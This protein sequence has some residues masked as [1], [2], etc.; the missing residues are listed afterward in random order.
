MNIRQILHILKKSSAG[1][2][3]GMFL[4]SLFSL[5]QASD[6]P[7]MPFVPTQIF[8]NNIPGAIQIIRGNQQVTVPIFIVGGPLAYND[9]KLELYMWVD[10]NGSILCIENPTGTSAWQFKR[11]DS[12]LDCEGL[13]PPLIRL[14]K[15]FHFEFPVQ[16]GALPLSSSELTVHMCID[17][18]YN[19]QL[20]DPTLSS[21]VYCVG[22][23]IQIIE[24]PSSDTSSNNSSGDGGSSSSSSSGSSSTTYAGTFN[25]YGGNTSYVSGGSSSSSSSGSSSTTYAGTFNNYGGNSSYVSGGGSSSSSSGSSSTSSNSYSSNPLLALLSSTGSTTTF[26]NYTSNSNNNSSHSCDETSIEIS[27]AS[28]KFYVDTTS[29]EKKLFVYLKNGCG[30]Y[31]E[32]EITVPEE[33]PHADKITVGKTGTGRFYVTCKTAGLNIGTHDYGNVIITD[34][35]GSQHT[36]SLTVYVQD[37]ADNDNVRE[38]REGMYYFDVPAKTARYFK[39]T[40]DRTRADSSK[41]A[42]LQIGNTPYSDQPTTVHLLIKQDSKPTVEEFRDTWGRPSQN[43]TSPDGLYYYYNTAHHAE[44]IEIKDIPDDHVITYYIMLYNDG[45]RDV[46]DQ[47]LTVTINECREVRRSEWHKYGC[48]SE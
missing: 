31:V 33:N 40:V 29:T 19:N 46:R 37:A 10:E 3:F 21:E 6:A 14:P 39:V 5:A 23:E 11:K 41:V 20:D 28:L 42:F 32:G 18:A 12:F 26:S 27:P 43:E 22:Q 44:F 7:T 8:L 38:L 2:L 48:I 36:V 13:V 35:N 25:N 16:I 1:F 45:D 4:T 17:T 15:Y 47:R 30:Q 24:P 34:V 9:G